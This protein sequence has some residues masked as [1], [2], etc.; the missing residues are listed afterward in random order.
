VT[1]HWSSPDPILAEGAEWERKQASARIM[2]E[3]ERRL[4]IFINLPLESLDR[5]SLKT[6]VD[7][8]GRS[9]PSH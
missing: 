6:K 2:S 1:A 8:I 5:L 9:Q 4:R 7:E 3:L